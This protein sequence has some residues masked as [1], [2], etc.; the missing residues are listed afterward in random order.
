MKILILVVFLCFM[1]CRTYQYGESPFSLAYVGYL[2]NEVDTI[3]VKCYQKD[4]SFSVLRDSLL[5]TS[6]SSVIHRKNDTTYI[7]L[8]GTNRVKD[9]SFFDLKIINPTDNKTIFLSDIQYEMREGSK[10]LFSEPK[11][12]VSA[13][14]SH[15][16]NDT[17]ITSLAQNLLNPV[18]Y[19]NK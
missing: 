7:A 15:K 13:L 4:N 12:C 9:I 17:I 14:I 16:V 11:G 10:G 18:L 19:I 5:L 3:I 1:S 2:P 6:N 8:L